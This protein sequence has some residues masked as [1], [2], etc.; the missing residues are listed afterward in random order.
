ME[1]ATADDGTEPIYVRQYNTSG[2]VVRT[3]ASLDG[4]GNSTFPGKLYGYVLSL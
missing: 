3:A 2:A 1:I 4:S